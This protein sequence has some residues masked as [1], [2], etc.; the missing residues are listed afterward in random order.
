MNARLYD[1]VL[2]RMLSADNYVGEG[3]QGLNR[4]SYANNNPLNRIDP[5]GNWVH[6]VVGAV[7]GGIVNLGVKAYNGQISSWSDGFAAF[8]IGAAGGAI[9]AATGGAAAGALGLGTTGVAS[10]VVTGGVGAVFGSPV[11]GV[12]NSLYFNDPSYSF[13]QWGKDILMGAGIGGIVSGGVALFKGQNVWWGNS[14]RV[15]GPWAL[16]K[17]KPNPTG[18]MGKVEVSELV[19]GRFIDDFDDG[20]TK[21]KA[22]DFGT[23][24]VAE[25]YPRNGGAFGKWESTFLM[26][27]TEIDRFGSGFGKYFSPRGTPMDMRALPTG[28]TG[29]YNIFKVLKPFEVQSSTIAP[30]FN[31]LGLGTQYL[32]PVNVNTLL[33]RGIISRIK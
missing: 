29:D 31:K 33:K 28:N 11:T 8:G 9:T 14:P 15:S 5:D 21:I 3:T 2:G 13:N 4:Y 17:P 26:P 16:P 30:A 6:I 22:H 7:I 27:G 10:G 19:D 25:Y 32:S 23:K 1:P 24:A 20:I 18:R 12:G